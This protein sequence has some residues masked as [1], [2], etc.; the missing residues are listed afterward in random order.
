MYHARPGA[1]RDPGHDHLRCRRRS[2]VRAAGRYLAR[3]ERRQA[4]RGLQPW[5]T[6]R[7]AA[8][9]WGMGV[10]LLGTAGVYGVWGQGL[11]FFP[12]TSPRQVWIDLE[13]PSG[14]NLDTADE[15]VRQVETITAETPDLRDLSAGVGSTSISLNSPQPTGVVASVSRVTLDLLDNR[16]RIQDSLRTLEQVRSRIAGLTGAEVTVDKP[17]DGPPTG[18][19]VVVR[20]IG[21]DFGALGEL[22]RTVKDTIRVVP[23]LV[24]LAD[25]YDQGKPEIRVRVDRVQASV[26]GVNTREIAERS[27]SPFAGRKRRPIGSGRTSTTSGYASHRRRARSTHSRTS[28]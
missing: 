27:R 5:V 7:R 14:T 25:D 23:G 4:I 8:V 11:E 19:P 1:G 15:I 10:I 2:G 26:A 13:V 21:D 16:D 24:N 22:S 18:K 3:L 12:E 6:D 9:L 17:A 20:I 28:R